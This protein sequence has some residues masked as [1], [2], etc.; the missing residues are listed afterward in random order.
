[1]IVYL[2]EHMQPPL[3]RDLL[4]DKNQIPDFNF[5]VVVDFLSFHHPHTKN[6]LQNRC[7]HES[8]VRICVLYEIRMLAYMI[9]GKRRNRKRNKVLL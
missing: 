8:T 2:S 1:M 4:N 3:T 5:H 9:L 7:F 6:V